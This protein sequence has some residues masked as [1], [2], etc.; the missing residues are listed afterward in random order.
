[1]DHG[2][3]QESVIHDG[4]VVDEVKELFW[5]NNLLKVL[6]ENDIDYF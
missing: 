3:L 2:G 4:L 5:V 1:M 6:G